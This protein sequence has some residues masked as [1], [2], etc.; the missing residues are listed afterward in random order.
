MRPSLCAVSAALL[1][2]LIPGVGLAQEPSAAL[3][4]QPPEAGGVVVQLGGGV[5]LNLPQVGAGLRVGTGLG[6][7]LSVTAL[8]VGFLGYSVDARLGWGMALGPELSLGLAVGAGLAS[9]EDANDLGGIAFSNLSLG[10]DRVAGGEV[11]LTWLRPQSATITASLGWSITLAGTRYDNFFEATYKP[12][13]ELRGLTASLQGEW[14][15]TQTR[16]LF[17]RL[18]GLLPLHTEIIPVGY[19]PTLTAGVTWSL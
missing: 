17:L 7:G 18:E 16:A 10:N 5:L 6:T 19:L 1:A 13:L 3:G 4:A 11:L 9:L 12:D 8:T 15:L 14:A 2:S